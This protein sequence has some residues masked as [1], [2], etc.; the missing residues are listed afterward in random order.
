MGRKNFDPESP[1]VILMEARG[2]TVK[3]LSEKSGVAPTT[4]YYWIHGK[5]IP[6]PERNVFKNLCEALGLDHGRYK[7]SILM[8]NYYKKVNFGTVNKEDDFTIK[9][10]I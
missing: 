10:L 2:L 3:E 9:D 5:V 4:L 8:L 6:D 7:L 1:L